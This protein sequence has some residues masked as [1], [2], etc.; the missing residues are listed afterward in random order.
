[1]LTTLRIHLN[2]A[3]AQLPS[4]VVLEAM[5]AH[6]R[7]EAELGPIEAGRERAEAAESLYLEAARLIGASP[8]EIAWCGS[9]SR[10]WATAVEAFDWRRGERII[11]SGLDYG[12]SLTTLAAAAA[13]SGAVIEVGPCDGHG[14]L[15]PE[16]LEILLGTG[17]RAVA[18]SHVAAHCGAS[19]DLAAIGRLTRR[20]GVQ[21]VVDA[22]QS[23][24]QLPL[25]VDEIGC[26]ALCAP[27]RKWLRGP[28]GSGLLYLRASSTG[29]LTPPWS[30]VV[31]AQF[32]PAAPNRPTPETLAPLTW[33]SGARRFELWE[34]S[35]AAAI[36]LGV[37][38]A[39]LN[40]AVDAG[41]YFERIRELAERCRT[42]LADIAGVTV[43]GPGDPDSAIIGFE[44]DGIAAPEV[45]ARCAAAGITIS[46]IE[47]S[48]APLAFAGRT[49]D[50]LCR[51][52]A[53][54]SNRDDDIDA[55][56]AVIRSMRR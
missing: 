43:W 25:S 2:S 52:S 20:A 8:D 35:R 45:Q 5:I 6:L 23:I 17:P 28:R 1:M 16:D 29:G 51:V 15:I 9:G 49:P 19:N 40:A 31:S 39:Q 41:G 14:R 30:D 42:G 27:G 24:G 11:V 53:H 37:A 18:V 26:D 38:L 10:A 47:S 13:R 33:R 32:V 36:G 34:R 3:G 54:V 7:A 50:Q 44:V 55:F 4:P 46:V 12:G 21:F 48:A 22:A 56:L